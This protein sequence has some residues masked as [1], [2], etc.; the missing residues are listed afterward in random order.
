VALSSRPRAVP[1]DAEERLVRFAELVDL[2]VR[3]AAHLAELES[4]AAT[5]PLT[6]LANKRSFDDRLRREFER[7]RRHGRALALAMLDIDHFKAVNDRHG[8]DGGDAVLLEVARRLE[9]EARPGDLL[10]RV[11]GEEFAWILPESD[12]ADGWAAAERARDAVARTPFPGVGR[13]TLSAGVADTDDGGDAAGLFNAADQALYAAKAGGRNVCVRYVP[14][15][16][17]VRRAAVE[18]TEGERFQALVALRALARAIDAR[19]PAMR[20]HSE[21]VGDLAVSLATALGRAVGSAVLI[22]EAALVHD[23]GEVAGDLR[24]HPVLGAQMVHG[25]L[26]AEQADWIRA[27]HEHFDGTGYPDGRAGERI[28]IEARILAVA[29]VWDGLVNDAPGRPARAP[30]EALAEI[31]AGAGTRFCPTVVGALVRL[32]RA[33]ALGGG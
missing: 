30:R 31:R 33:G 21:R 11:G 22:R 28:P 20:G 3:N 14:D 1:E 29:D 4:R 26:S 24:Q 18:A 23:V 6:G 13:L 32:G 2:S 7:S 15:I 5:D 16:G 8:H 12:A 19:H 25:I 10:A 9:R 27:H 17:A